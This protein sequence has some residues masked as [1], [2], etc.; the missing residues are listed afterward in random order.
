MKKVKYPKNDPRNPKEK[1]RKRLPEIIL[2]IW[3]IICVIVA[4]FWIAGWF[5]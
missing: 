1:L 5:K 4:G 3:W 2:G